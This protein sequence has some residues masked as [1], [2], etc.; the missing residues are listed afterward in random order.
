MFF[1]GLAAALAVVAV[2]RS[3]GRGGARRN[4]PNIVLVSIDT[5]RADHLG[6]YGY[7]RATSPRLDQ[8]AGESIRY[9]RALAPTPWTLPSHAAML[10]GRHPLELGIFDSDGTLPA[11][12]TTLAEYLKTAGYASAAFVDSE[13][14][15]FV[16]A[17]RGFDRGFDRFEHAPHKLRRTHLYDMAATVRVGLDWL[18]GRPTDR[19]FFLFLHTKSVHATPTE[20]AESDAPYD[21]PGPYRHRFLPQ[22]RMLFGW[23]DDG[24]FGTALLRYW[25]EELAGGTLAREH[26]A[27]AQLAELEALYDG[28]IYYTDK[29]FGVLLD[30]LRA[31][32]LERDTVI[33]VT[34]DHG[35]AFLEHDF[36]LHQ[37]LF[38][39]LLEV[40]LLLRLP[41]AGRGR[42]VRETVH[43]EDIVPTLIRLAGI[44]PPAQLAGRVL[45][46]VLPDAGARPAE[47][48]HFSFFRVG[49]ARAYEAYGVQDGP[50]LFVLDRRGQGGSFAGRLYD[51]RVDPSERTPTRASAEQK[52]AAALQAFFQPGQARPQGALKMSPETIELLRSL[53][54]TE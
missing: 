17:R 24:V 42:L 38:R 5:L 12:A 45:P 6:V 54:Y 30:G 21:K 46:G 39:E 33:V 51:R 32:G 49:A 53:G 10:T 16:G 13:P 26:F 29:Y 41:N 31:R 25:N 4:R 3:D 50:Y 48:P 37:E 2:L 47:R 15:T 14:D 43:L 11:G 36:F 23:R 40:P 9:A 19:P 44:T 7:G 8:F 52:L 18:D 27:P 20:A 35:E 1:A 22:G 28:G 34:A